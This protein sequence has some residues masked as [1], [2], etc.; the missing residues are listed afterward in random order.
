M[1]GADA[2]APGSGSERCT[3]FGFEFAYSG[4]RASVPLA[5]S[6][7]SSDGQSDFLEGLLTQGLMAIPAQ[8]ID[9][10]IGSL[11]GAIQGALREGNSLGDLFSGLGETPVDRS[12]TSVDA[13][14]APPPAAA[15]PVPRR[16][17]LDAA[18]GRLLV[19]SYARHEPARAG[20][21][22]VREVQ[23]SYDGSPVLET[24]FRLRY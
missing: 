1:T 6:S 24:Q 2:C 5:C 16:V 12:G 21:V 23:C 8:D 9:S 13:T 20:Q 11:L 22:V 3:Q 15:P 19:P 7:T 17:T 10:D 4:A 14:S 18:S